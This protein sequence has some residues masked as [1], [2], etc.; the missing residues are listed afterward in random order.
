L[1]GYDDQGKFLKTG[2]KQMPLLSSIRAR[3]KIQ[4]TT[5]QTVLSGSLER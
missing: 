4:G 5:G 3:R 1:K 2:R